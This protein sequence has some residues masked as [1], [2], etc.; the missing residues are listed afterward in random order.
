METFKYIL[1]VEVE[2]EAFNIHD[3]DEV[4]HDNFGDVPGAIV[5]KL[6]VIDVSS[7]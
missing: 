4:I 1:A 5:K 2:V 6:Q 3:A 7:D